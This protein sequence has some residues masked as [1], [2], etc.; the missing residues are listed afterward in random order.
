VGLVVDSSSLV[1][2][3]RGLIDLDALLATSAEVDIVISAV[4]AAE[5]LHGVERL[6]GVSRVR[7]EAFVESVVALVPTIAFDLEIARTHTVLAADLNRRGVTI[8]A[9][10]LLIAAT[11]VALDYGVATRDRRNYPKIKGLQIVRW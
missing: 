10:D 3:E 1:A 5:L 8:G 2:A 11:A 9:H 4:T 7:A 6:S